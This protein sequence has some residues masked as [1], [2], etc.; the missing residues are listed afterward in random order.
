MSIMIIIIIL[1]YVFVL[2]YVV[3]IEINS[4]K[5]AL[6]TWCKNA[7]SWQDK[8]HETDVTTPAQ[9]VI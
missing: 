5:W 1:A 9:S 3:K 4:T 6:S 2:L 7:N 8:F